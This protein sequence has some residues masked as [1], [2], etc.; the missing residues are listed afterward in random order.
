MCDHAQRSP[1]ARKIFRGSRKARKQK[2]ARAHICA[3]RSTANPEIQ[4]ARNS[5]RTPRGRTL[6]LASVRRG[7]LGFAGQASHSGRSSIPI[8]LTLFRDRRYYP[9]NPLDRRYNL[10]V[11]LVREETPQQNVEY[12][13][14]NVLCQISFTPARWISLWKKSFRANRLKRAFG[15]SSLDPFL[16]AF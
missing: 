8:R 12:K 7:L 2:C 1:S 15:L 4:P 3:E 6:L 16:R 11:A 14:N 13:E 10:A 5:V 9:S